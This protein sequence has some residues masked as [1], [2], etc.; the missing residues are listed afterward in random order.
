MKFQLK[1]QTPET[2]AALAQYIADCV[3]YAKGQTIR[4]GDEDVIMTWVRHKGEFQ[5]RAIATPAD[6][7]LEMITLG[8]SPMFNLQYDHKVKDFAPT[9][10][11]TIPGKRNPWNFKVPRWIMNTNSRQSVRFRNKNPLDMRRSNLEVYDNGS[12]RPAVNPFD[13]IRTRKV[14]TI[15][16]R[17][18]NCIVPIDAISGYDPFYPNPGFLVQDR[19]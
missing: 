6:Q 7:V 11:I 15:L 1:D 9:K 4:L 2:C 5:G 8:I 19:K 18:P 17:M 14:P 12:V 13:G 10:T 3:E 16:F